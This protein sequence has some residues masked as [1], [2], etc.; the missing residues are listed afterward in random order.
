MHHP[1]RLS[2]FAFELQLQNESRQIVRY[3]RQATAQR[4]VA[5]GN[6]QILPEISQ[7]YIYIYTYTPFFHS[8]L[9]RVGP[10][11]NKPEGARFSRTVI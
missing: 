3:T 4:L 7:D 5:E 8:D 10:I 2:G 6:S 9:L 11:R 1:Q